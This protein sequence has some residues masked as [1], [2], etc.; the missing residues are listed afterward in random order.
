[1]KRLPTLLQVMT[2]R[3]C[4]PCR[5][6]RLVR[7]P[8][9]KG[10][11]YRVKHAASII[12][13]AHCGPARYHRSDIDDSD[14]DDDDD[15]EEEDEEEEEEE[16]GALPAA[17]VGMLVLLLVLLLLVVLLPGWWWWWWWW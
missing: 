13:A 10:A 3:S 9:Q 17:G 16:E 6:S 15:E 11:S 5:S 12:V 4:A 8:S 2:F 14:E 7:M 1:M